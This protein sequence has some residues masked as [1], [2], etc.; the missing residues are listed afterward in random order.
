[1]RFLQSAVNAVAE[2]ITGVKTFVSAI[3]ASAGVTAGDAMLALQSGLG[4]GSSDVV[5]RVGSSVVD[6]S[7]DAAAKLFQVTTGLGGTN[8]PYFAV[9]KTGLTLPGWRLKASG[10]LGGLTVNAAGFDVCYWDSTFGELRPVYGFRV[11]DTSNVQSMFLVSSAT[12]LLSQYGTN[13]SASPGT[14][15]INKPI[16]KAA[17]A[18]GAASVVITNSLVTANSVVLITPHARDATCKELI[19]VPTAGSFTV[20]GSAVATAAL[21]FSFEVKTIL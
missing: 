2:T 8:T 20:S 19:A 15:T 17:I 12:G 10:G 6:G 9:D 5:V 21:P 7:V 18:I 3:V 13:S 16:G 4:A 1:M 11:M 14:A